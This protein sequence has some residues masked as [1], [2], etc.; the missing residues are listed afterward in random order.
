M[1]M[2]N[3]H[4]VECCHNVCCE[5]NIT[6]GLLDDE[7]RQAVLRRLT[8]VTERERERQNY[9]SIYHSDIQCATVKTAA[10]HKYMA[11]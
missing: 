5:T 2:F 11:E 4:T 10:F 1:H 3:T 6:M 9:E 8:H 7:Q